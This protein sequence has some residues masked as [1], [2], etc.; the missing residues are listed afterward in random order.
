MRSSEFV[1]NQRTCDTNDSAAIISSMAPSHDYDERSLNGGGNAP[2]AEVY[3]RAARDNAE[4]LARAQAKLSNVRKPYV[5][6]LF[7]RLYS[8]EVVDTR[9]HPEECDDNERIGKLTILRD[10][11]GFTGA[12]VVSMDVDES[13]IPIFGVSKGDTFD[14][15][16]V[17]AFKN[18]RM[19]VRGPTGTITIPYVL[20]AKQALAT[21]AISFPAKPARAA[22]TTVELLQRSHIPVL[23]EIV[24]LIQSGTAHTTVA[25]W[26]TKGASRITRVGDF[27]DGTASPKV[28]WQLVAVAS[29]EK[30]LLL[31][32]KGSAP[33][34]F[35]VMVG[36]TF[37][38][39][40]GGLGLVHEILPEK[41]TVKMGEESRSIEFWRLCSYSSGRL[42]DQKDMEKLQV[43]PV[44]SAP[45]ET[46]KRKR[47]DDDGEE[48][49]G[50]GASGA[51][52]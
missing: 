28:K 3:E 42:Q 4:G 40:G 44:P 23:P 11:N 14:G 38:T 20:V 51:A 24:E 34:M 29:K 47:E 26:T 7:T 25:L 8:D 39:A 6:T 19:H 36:D 1:L 17:T 12:L 22:F 16:T 27:M 33:I 46:K 50:A 32:F 52:D 9:G 13:S 41:F 31:E 35:R 21:Y 10:N 5:E 18:T 37:P 48:E 15:A 49:K 45:S 30:A 2:S 43:Y